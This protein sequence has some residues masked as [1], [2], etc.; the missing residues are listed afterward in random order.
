MIIQICCQKCLLSCMQNFAMLILQSSK[1]WSYSVVTMLLKLLRRRFYPNHVKDI[2]MIAEKGRITE[3][4]FYLLIITSFYQLNLRYFGMV[5]Q[6]TDPVV[7]GFQKFLSSLTV[8]KLF[9]VLFKRCLAGQSHIQD[10]HQHRRL[11]AFCC[12]ALHLRSLQESWVRSC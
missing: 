8:G 11:T 6:S 7:Q 4:V 12:R 10:Y 1:I 3:V 5:S 2:D 9:A